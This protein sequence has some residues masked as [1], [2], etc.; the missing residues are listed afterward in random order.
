[1]PD[2]KRKRR[3]EPVQKT[4]KQPV[5]RAEQQPMPVQ[6]PMQPMDAVQHETSILPPQPTEDMFPVGGTGGALESIVGP[7]GEEQIAKA[8]EILNRY[9][10]GKRRL[11]Q[12]VIECEQW[13]KLRHWEYMHDGNPN[14][15]QPASAWLFNCLMNKHAD[16]IE[17]Y[18]EPNIR[19]REPGDKDEAKI[20]SA[21]VPVILEQNDFEETYSAALWQ[22]LKQGTGIY[23]VVW[24][25][26]K[27]NG[28][29]DVGIHKIDALNIYWEPGVTDIQRSRNV[30]TTELVDK[31][32]LREMY[33]DKL[34]QGALTGKAF[35]PAKY[36]YDDSVD[37]TDKAVVIDW[38][39]HKHVDGRKVLH[40]VKYVDKYVLYASEN[41]PE[42]RDRGLYDHGLYPFVFDPLFPIEGSPCGYGFI[43][44]GKGPQATIDRLNQAIE[45]NALMG[46]TPRWF[47]SG[48]GSVNEAEFAD[49]TKPFVHV[50]N[51]QLGD[52]ALRQISVDPLN[53][54]YAN[55]LT[56]KIDE[57][58]ETTGNRDVTNGG[59]QSGVTAASAIATMAEMSNKGSRASNKAS[60]RAYARIINMVIELIRQF[61]TL[62]RQYRIVGD[63]NQEEFV[64][65]SNA[66][67]QPQ[68]QGMIGGEDMGYR[69]PVF[70]IDVSAQKM[71]AYTKVAQNEMALQMYQLGVFEPANADRS[72]ALLDIMDFEGKDL[73][74]DKV[75]AN[76][77]MY[78]MLAM[79]QQ[80]CI[81]LAMQAGR[82]DVA[83]SL[84]QNVLG[85][86]QMLGGMHGVGGNAPAQ[87]ANG[88]NVSQTEGIKGKEHPFVEKARAQAQNST[89]VGGG[90]GA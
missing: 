53:A 10:S 12:R 46:S 80:M 17:A 34:P 45:K 64:S 11:E 76:G 19:P 89:Q 25:K 77:T 42:W 90:A 75:R 83:E 79:Y 78:Q 8:N 3:P 81:Q 65:Y 36:I 62:P 27:L 41:D 16:G 28:L 56:N 73:I 71:T 63:N 29:G 50:L 38:Y 66:G 18:P 69:L 57:L 14:D 5:M 44:I 49:W 21:I 20:L 60:Y 61:Y 6:R 47:I 70:D 30:F 32:L 43:D 59:T 85:T 31:D 55:V 15:D 58:K 26:D 86:Q 87:F 72:L 35:Q 52:D 48:A 84:A 54:I 67:L 39:Y 2:N 13:W 4:D 88:V 23:A 1:M 74:E 7:V 51:G 33:A 68:Y 82:P 22:K 40:Y 9:R 37:V 24:Q